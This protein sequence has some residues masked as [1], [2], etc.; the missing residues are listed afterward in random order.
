MKNCF[1]SSVVAAAAAL[2]CANALAV[3]VVPRLGVSLNYT[4]TQTNTGSTTKPG[5]NAG[6]TV[7]ASSVFGDVQ[8][9]T[10]PMQVR[11]PNN[12]GMAKN[13]TDGWRTEGAVS[14]GVN[15]WESLS[16]IAGYRSVRYGT[17]A[18]KSD[19]ATM[20]GGFIGVALAN[21]K[22]T[23][24]DIFSVSVA[25]QP[26]TYK[27]KAGNYGEETDTG[28]SIKIGY[29]RAGSPHAFSIRHQAFGGDKSY[30]EAVTSLQYNYL[31]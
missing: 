23:E 4:D 16:L 8:V 2:A 14:V 13:M 10:L 30:D 5:V 22:M 28:V 1:V 17:S 20:T 27:A 18:G 11:D 29:R 21:L 24:K 3:D 7:S 19:S 6:L 26:T 25:L 15:V 12:T 31:F 9:E